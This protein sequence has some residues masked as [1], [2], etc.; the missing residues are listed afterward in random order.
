[1]SQRITVTILLI[2]VLI[3][4]VLLPFILFPISDKLILVEAFISTGMLT[5]FESNL[6]LGVFDKFKKEDKNP[7]L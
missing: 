6:L 1:M 3:G 2:I 4:L 7:L 5:I